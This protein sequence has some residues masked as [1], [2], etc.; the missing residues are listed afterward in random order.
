MVLYF[1]HSGRV[2]EFSCRL[3]PFH[4]LPAEMTTTKKLDQL[5]NTAKEQQR[6][7][8]S[9]VEA[10]GRSCTFHIWTVLR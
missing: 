7:F 2:C 1:P 4:A 10:F 8:S 6:N 9:G 3:T 5:R